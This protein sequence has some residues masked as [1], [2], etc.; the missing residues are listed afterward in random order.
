MEKIIEIYA[1]YAQQLKFWI[2]SLLIV[3]MITWETL[4]H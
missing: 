2:E 4:S 3:F 1:K